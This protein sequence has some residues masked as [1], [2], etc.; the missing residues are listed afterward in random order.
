MASV[1]LARP[2]GNAS[3][4]AALAQQKGIAK[5]SFETLTVMFIIG[6][7]F[8]VM[9]G[10]IRPEEDWIAKHEQWKLDQ[11]KR[12]PTKRAVDKSHKRGA[13]K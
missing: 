8:I 12:R 4:W 1:L 6:I 9:L 10:V 13:K 2:A 5:M 11:R 7:G 3:R